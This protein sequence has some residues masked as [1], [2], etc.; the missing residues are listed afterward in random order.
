MLLKSLTFSSLLCHQA[1]GNVPATQENLLHELKIHMGKGEKFSS[2]KTQAMKSNLDRQEFVQVFVGIANG[3]GVDL[4]ETCIE[5]SLEFGQQAEE[6]VKMLLSKDPTHVKSALRELGVVI[7]HTLPH[8]LR[9]CGGS[10]DSLATLIKSCAAF[11]SPHAFAYH[12]GKDLLINGVDIFKHVNAAIKA[13]KEG[14]YYDFGQNI[15]VALREISVGNA[16]PAH[17][18]E[19]MLSYD[20][21][22]PIHFRI[23]DSAI[24]DRAFVKKVAKLSPYLSSHVQGVIEVVPEMDASAAVAF[25]LGL[26]TGFGEDPPKACIQAD[27]TLAHLLDAAFRAMAKGTPYGVAIAMELFSRAYKLQLPK[28]EKNCGPMVKDAVSQIKEGLSQFTSPQE[29]VVGLLHNISVNK[30]NIQKEIGMYLVA[31]KG[32]EWEEA[33]VQLGKAI[34]LVLLGSK[35]ES[36]TFQAAASGGKKFFDKMVGASYQIFV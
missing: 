11:S 8:A 33:G 21:Q 35:E 3:F 26:F 19:V 28:V 32:G 14:N 4:K 27:D 22:E 20:E 6:A 16:P 18:V 7:I 1:L 34:K 9:E 29:L 25:T 31:M 13:W 23:S 10:Y 12:I 17:P 30:V 5:D 24:K 36:S 15:G 2:E